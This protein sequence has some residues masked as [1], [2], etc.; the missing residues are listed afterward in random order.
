MT[1][2]DMVQNDGFFVVR[3][4]TTRRT[5]DYQHVVTKGMF[6]ALKW[7]KVIEKIRIRHEEIIEE[8]S[9]VCTTQLNSCGSYRSTLQLLN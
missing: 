8:K 4:E 9:M 1:L 3:V 5:G 6:Y 2:T 7:E